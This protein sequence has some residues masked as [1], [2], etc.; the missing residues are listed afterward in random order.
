MPQLIS[1]IQH[2]NQKAA[3]LVQGVLSRVLHRFPQ[4]A[5]WPLAWLRHA[6]TG[7]RQTIG[8]GI[9]KAAKL[10]TKDEDMRRLLLASNDLFSY[11]HK[12]AG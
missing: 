1:Q 12:V 10:K 9:F 5:M 7:N 3:A 2:S 8:I 4:Q 11:L 6:T